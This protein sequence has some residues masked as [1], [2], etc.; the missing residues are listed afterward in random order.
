MNYLDRQVI[1][2]DNLFL[3]SSDYISPKE[4]I[5]SVRRLSK[6]FRIRSEGFMALFVISDSWYC[7]DCP[8]TVYG[9]CKALELPAS[10]HNSVYCLVETLVR[11]GLVE[12]MSMGN[13]HKYYIPTDKALEHISPLLR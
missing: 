1:E 13:V 11:K 12:P 10:N 6:L 4:S 3:K 5:L 9:V 8:L 2:R 7:R